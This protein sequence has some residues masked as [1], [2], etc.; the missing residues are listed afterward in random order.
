MCVCACIGL[1]GGVNGWGKCNSSTFHAT[2]TLS[3]SVCVS[4]PYKSPT[5]F[6]LITQIGFPRDEGTRE[7]KG[8]T[9]GP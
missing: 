6:T 1:V 9:G 5:L 4:L 2:V 3:L 7:E 8:V